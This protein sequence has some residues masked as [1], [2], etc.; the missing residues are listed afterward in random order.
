MLGRATGMDATGAV[1]ALTALRSDAQFQLDVFKG[2][3]TAGAT[4][5]LSIGNAIANADAVSYTHL[6]AHET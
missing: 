2:H 1:L 6:R 5:D 3:A 4:G